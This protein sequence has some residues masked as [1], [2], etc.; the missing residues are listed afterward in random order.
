MGFPR[1]EDIL[2][3][4]IPISQ[5]RLSSSRTNTEYLPN[6]V[7][8]NM[9]ESRIPITKNGEIS[10]YLPIVGAAMD[11][12]TA[13]FDIRPSYKNNFNFD[14]LIILAQEGAIGVIPRSED[15]NLKVQEKIIKG[16]KR[17]TSFIVRSPY[18][19]KPDDS[20]SKVQE[21][22]QIH[23]YSRY[24]VVTEDN[25]LK[26]VITRK[27]FENR[28]PNLLVKERMAKKV[29]VVNEKDLST[30]EDAD[31]FLD[32]Y[33]HS[34]LPVIDG[35]GYLKG[36]ITRRDINN[37]IYNPHATLDSQ[38]RYMVLVAVGTKKDDEEL[39]RLKSVD[40]FVV[41]ASV[42]RHKWVGE[43]VEWLKKHTDKPVIAGNVMG[44]HDAKYL[45]EIA[46]AVKV[47]YG[48]GAGCIS[49]EITG[50]GASV[51]NSIWDS[52]K[53]SIENN[54]PLIGDGGFKNSG[55]IVVGY[56]LGA[57]AI[58][59]GK[60][61]AHGEETPIRDMRNIKGYPEKIYRGMGSE[62]L[63]ESSG[64]Y[65]GKA[66]EGTE[67]WIKIKGPLGGILDDI[68]SGIMSGVSGLGFSSL[69]ELI[70][71]SDL[72]FNLESKELS[73]AKNIQDLK[74]VPRNLNI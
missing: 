74:T 24:P 33:R 22:F 42:G 70:R 62:P 54:I 57:S 18:T 15:I 67:S 14:A 36:L 66:P 60:M 29:D 31:T 30:I 6:D 10:L 51:A 68:E 63:I 25:K 27:D 2:V 37:L 58:M 19:V 39:K 11:T 17:A 45:A 26:G 69:Q 13:G 32:K 1:L 38:N 7:R 21:Y 4:Q 40:G 65:F 59:V 3:K 41:D 46:D 43:K 47:G 48:I 53:A 34:M 55:D 52:Y 72:I 8:K 71:N 49:S 50:I 20:L 56:G 73:G 12:V 28:D 44:Y 64:R 9:D 16:V 23:K 35:E 5:I 61:I